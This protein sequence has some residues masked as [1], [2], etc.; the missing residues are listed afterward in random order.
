M[1]N[2]SFSASYCAMSGATFAIVQNNDNKLKNA[3]RQMAEILGTK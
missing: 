2:R 3:I 1:I